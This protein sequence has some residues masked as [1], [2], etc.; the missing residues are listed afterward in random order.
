MSPMQV[1]YPKNPPKIKAIML[2]Y[3]KSLI[4]IMNYSK[5]PMI[6]GV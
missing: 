6:V 5:S 4:F 3:P 2:G 1:D